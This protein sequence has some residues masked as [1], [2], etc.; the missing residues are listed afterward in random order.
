LNGRLDRLEPHVASD[1]RFIALVALA[2]AVGQLGTN[3]YL[4]AL[5]LMGQEFGAS[6]AMMAQTLTV[7]LLGCALA[8]LVAGPLSDAYGRRPVILVGL[9]VYGAGALCCGAA[10][11]VW[12]LMAGRFLQSVGASCAPV[13]GRAMIKDATPEHLTASRLG[14]LGVAMAATPALAPVMGGAITQVFG[15]RPVF[16]VLSVICL[17]VFW[18][19][20]STMPE[21]LDAARRVPLRARETLAAYR[22]LLGN[23]G[24][25]WNLGVLSGA[26]MGMGVLSAGAPFLFIRVYHFSPLGYGLTNL[27]NV[28]GFI[29]GNGLAVRTLRYKSMRWVYWVSAAP[30]LASGAL[31]FAALRAGDAHPYL[32]IASITLFATGIGGLFPISTKNALGSGKAMAGAASALLGFGQIAACGAGSFLFA[33]LSAANTDVPLAIGLLNLFYTALIALA[34]WPALLRGAVSDSGPFKNQK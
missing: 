31:M 12:S 18:I 2:I 8:T 22:A 6:T 32:V 9:A 5:P 26:F 23:G 17:L 4:P 13:A 19:C 30:T 34:A 7:Y 1:A 15:W 21:T 3:L 25:C 14:L 27:A 29:I 16:W 33:A 10:G 11:G 24:F 20:R 28:L